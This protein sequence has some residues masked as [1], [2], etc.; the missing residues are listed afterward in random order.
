MGPAHVENVV[1]LACRTALAR[2]GV[3]HITIPVDMQDRSRSR[4]RRARK[5]NVAGT[6]LG[7]HGPRRAAAADED[8]LRRAAEHA[9]RRQEGRHPGRPGR[10]RRAATSSSRSPSC[11]ARR[12]SRRCSARRVVP[13]DSPYTTGGIGLL[14]TRPSQE[15]LEECDTLLMVG[16][17][18][19]Y[20]EFY[21]KPGQARAVQ[22]DLDPARIGLRYPVEVGLVGDAQA[23]LRGA[24]AAAR[25]QR[26]PRV[27]REGPGGHEGLARADGRA[28]H[29]A[30]HADEAAGRRARAGQAAGRRRDRR[31]ATPARSPPGRRGTSDDARRACKFSCSGTLATMAC[32][33]PY[34]I[35]AA[36]RLSRT[37]RSSPSSATAASRC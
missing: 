31:H 17:T 33:L 3:A 12:S 1:E 11:W 23:T 26:G 9:Q 28:R 27:P 5:R 13:D 20:I 21:P 16:T 35:A 15:A 30:R 8:Q 7:R 6:R 34:A 14:G 18:F 4:R 32:G 36:G 19:P 37:G 2:R 10:A 24:A 25:A 29:P 22:I